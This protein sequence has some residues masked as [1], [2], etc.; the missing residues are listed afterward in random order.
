[1]GSKLRALG[2]LIFCLACAAQ[3]VPGK[4]GAATPVHWIF[5]GVGHSPSAYGTDDNGSAS[6]SVST[7][8]SLSDRF[9]LQG[10]LS[11]LSY[12]GDPEATFIGLGTGARLYPFGATASGGGVFVDASP[13]LY[14]ALWQDFRGITRHL[15][16][17]FQESAGVS[18]SIRGRFLMEVGA[19]YI[20]STDYEIVALD[21]E[22]LRF[23]GLSQGALYIRFGVP[24][25]WR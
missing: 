20:H 5:A 3:A 12:E 10:G 15:L 22:P 2:R 23:D 9:S 25:G 7:V 8:K 11:E 24:I 14:F 19:S 18:F 13:A 1:M 17:G 6:Y 21:G 16:V 4:A